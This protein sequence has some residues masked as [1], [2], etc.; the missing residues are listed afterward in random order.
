MSSRRFFYLRVAV[1]SAILFG[2]LLYAWRDIRGRELRTDWERTLRVALVLVPLEP[3]EPDAVADM[4]VRSRALEEQLATEMARYRGGRRPFAI[5][6]LIAPPTAAQAPPVAPTT[7]GIFAVLEYNWDQRSWT[8]RVDEAAGVD[9]DLFDA[10]IYLAARSGSV[11]MLTVEGT[12]QQGGRVG[13]VAIDLNPS[14]VDVALFVAAHELFHV[15][16]ASDKYT[17]DGSVMIP[18]G[19]ADPDQQPLYPQSG[20][21][22]MARHRATG[23]R[24]SVMPQGLD[25]LRVGRV[26]AKEINWI[27]DN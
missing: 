9:A 7:D 14:M 27:Q 8:D 25:E 4:R 21:E 17:A 12:A 22:V 5:T 6:L 11:R 19:L 23:P 3:L 10:R 26:T 15:L 20:A 24:D 16:G 13:I 1:L 18:D 2:V